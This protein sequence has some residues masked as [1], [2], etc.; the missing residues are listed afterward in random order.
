MS[1]LFMVGPVVTLDILR[2]VCP[3][4]PVSIL[5]KRV[6][7]LQH[8]CEV[9]N[10]TSPLRA[11]AL[12]A[13]YAYESAWFTAWVEESSDV[14]GPDFELYDLPHRVAKLLGNT[15][16]GDGKKFRGRGLVQITGRW[17]Y[18]AAGKALGI[19]LVNHPELAESED[20]AAAIA[21]WYWTSRNLNDLAD[22]EDF[23]GL[24]KKINGGTNGLKFRQ[25]AYER[26]KK[27]FG[28]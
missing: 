23:V 9:A 5:E 22:K 10:A 2:E 16:K 20:V 21:A 19:D 18:A 1:G 25:K 28:V 8:T 6:P 7:L 26:A 24:T 14:S 3:H 27:A 12:I 13:Q 11:A 17:N 4:T 15:Q